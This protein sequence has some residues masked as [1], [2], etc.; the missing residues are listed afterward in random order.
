VQIALDSFRIAYPNLGFKNIN[1][2]MKEYRF[3]ECGNNV[4]SLLFSK[5]RQS[6][7]VS[8]EILKALPTYKK[9]VFNI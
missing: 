6:Y 1:V 3:G 4:T 7:Q 8:L 9:V 5:F 2:L